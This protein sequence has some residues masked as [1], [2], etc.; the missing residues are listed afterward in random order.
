MVVTHRTTRGERVAQ[1][2]AVRARHVVGD[3]GKRRGA[4]VGGDH[5]VCI[6]TVTTHHPRRRHHSSAGPIDIV[7]HIQQA[8]HE[9]PVTGDALLAGRI[10]VRRGVAGRGGRSLDHESALGAD[11]DDHSVLHRLRLHQSQDLGA[12]VLPA[13]TPAQTA[14]RHRTE[15][16]VY[17]LDPGRVDEDLEFRPGKR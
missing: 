14:A 17:T 10:P 15:T 6:V 7:G 9:Q 1:P 13:I 4:L 8:R 3:I 2:E 11:R 5:Q 16:Q 12:E